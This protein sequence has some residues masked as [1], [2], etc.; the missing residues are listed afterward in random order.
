MR[1][2]PDGVAVG[3]ALERITPAYAGKTDT[4]EK[5]IT[6]SED[7]PRVCGENVHPTIRKRNQS[8]SPPRMRG[9]LL[10]R[11]RGRLLPRITPA[12][13]GKTYKP[14]KKKATARDHPRVCGE[15]LWSKTPAAAIQGSPPRMR[16]KL[17]NSTKT[18]L[19]NRITPAYAGKTPSDS[20]LN[21][22]W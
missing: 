21:T 1:G 3:A 20:R 8:G 15:N 5:T 11:V 7:H 19:T 18:L 17:S 10:H 4:G 14:T 16:G 9:K 2:K 22:S 12:Y 13:A 6:L